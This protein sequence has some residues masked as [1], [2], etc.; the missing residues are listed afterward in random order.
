MAEVRHYLTPYDLDATQRARVLQRARALKADYIAPR[1][2]RLRIGALYFNP[3][4]R[5]RASFEQAAWVLGGTCQTLNAMGDTWKLEL[6]PDAIMDGDTAE[7]I[8]EAARV[9]GRYFHVLGVR[10]FPSGK[11]P[12]DSERTEPVLRRF[13]EHAGCSVVSL[14]GAA[15]HPCQSLADQLTMQE[16][17]GQDLT[18]IP[19]AMTWAW[20]PRALPTAVPNAFVAQMALAGA[21][22]RIVHPEGYD[23]DAGFMAQARDAAAASGGR[24]TVSNDRAAVEGA[25][26]VYVK[27]WAPPGNLTPPVPELRHWITDEASLRGTDDAKVMHCL[28]VRRNVVIAGEVLD[29]PRAIVTQQAENRLWAQA[30]LVEFLWKEQGVRA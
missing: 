28:P 23:L 15:W 3:S 22:L 10:A 9:L 24:I 13:A 7:N 2:S 20:H 27:N 25:K 14:E 26:V 17:F 29:G 1:A 8:V 6:D 5:T 19:V 11:E 16:H 30:A 12:W 18:G 21:D 4:L